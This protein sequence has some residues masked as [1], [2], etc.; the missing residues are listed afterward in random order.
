MQ[1]VWDLI[2]DK[3]FISAYEHGFV[4]TCLDGIAR[5]FYPRIL[6]YSADYPEKYNLSPYTWSA[7]FKYLYSRM[8][9]AS[10]REKGLCPCPRCMVLKSNIDK[11]GF[12]QDAKDRLATARS[13]CQR[14]ISRA[15]EFI[16]EM[17]YGVTS[18]AVERL[19]K[20]QS[21]VPTLVG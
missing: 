7:F 19:L 14:L 1:N 10:I 4:A 11:I 15:R 6:T 20:P 17:G 12:V 2:L 9:I 18:A 21:L 3:E 16:Y 8:L 13:Y 5:R